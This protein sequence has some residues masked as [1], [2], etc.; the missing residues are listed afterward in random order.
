[1]ETVL[2]AEVADR[3]LHSGA[4]LAVEPVLLPAGHVAVELGQDLR[5]FGLE[6]WVVQQLRPGD[7]LRQDFDRVAV[8]RP[9]QAVDAAEQ[10]PGSRVP[11]P[12]HVVCQASEPFQ[13]RGSRKGGARERWDMHRVFH[14]TSII[15]D[16]APM[17]AGDEVPK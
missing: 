1:V 10:R 12:P 15:S 4:V 5:V 17:F 13:L 3:A 6:G 11:A 14:L 9:R 2:G 16:G 7:R 8:A